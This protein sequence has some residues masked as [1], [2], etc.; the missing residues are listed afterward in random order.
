M[1]LFKQYGAI[2]ILAIMMLGVLNFLGSQIFDNARA[3]TILR[4]KEKNNRMILM[5]VRQDVKW[6]RERASK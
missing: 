2:G 4:E 1:D 5:E 3:V 6:L